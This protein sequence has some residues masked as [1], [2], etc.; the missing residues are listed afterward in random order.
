MGVK[1]KLSKYEKEKSIYEIWSTDSVSQTRFWWFMMKLFDIQ[2]K[3]HKNNPARKKNLHIKWINQT[4]P[5]IILAEDIVN[6]HK[7]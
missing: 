3:D 1:Q 4:N 2:N 7:T 6:H 5:I